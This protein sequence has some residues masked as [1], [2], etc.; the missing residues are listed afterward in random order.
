M[1]L[2]KFQSMFPRTD[3]QHTDRMSV[4]Q[5]Q[6]GLG[7]GEGAVS[8][9]CFAFSFRSHI[10]DSCFSSIIENIKK[11]VLHMRPSAGHSPWEVTV[12]TSDYTV[13]PSLQDSG[14][15]SG[16]AMSPSAGSGSSRSIDGSTYESLMTCTGSQFAA[17]EAMKCTP[18]Q[19]LASHEDVVVPDTATLSIHC[20]TDVDQLSVLLKVLQLLPRTCETVV[21][22]L[23]TAAVSSSSC[24]EVVACLRGYE[25]ILKKIEIEIET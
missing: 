6:A 15:P 1:P 14:L 10:G 16:P 20:V 7:E 25:N 18:D 9:L 22:G 23:K 8:S 21:I 2:D 11:Q 5:L 13:H 24:R 12:T 19:N 17:L 4:N 3:K